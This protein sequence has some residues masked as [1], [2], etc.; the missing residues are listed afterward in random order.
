MG[1]TWNVCFLALLPSREDTQTGS[2]VG[3]SRGL[4]GT[5]GTREM[6]LTF[7]PVGDALLGLVGILGGGSA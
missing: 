3:R 2:R 1:E 6:L 4:Q 5:R 7:P